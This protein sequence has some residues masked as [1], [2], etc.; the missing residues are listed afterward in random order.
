MSLVMFFLPSLFPSFVL[1]S[2]LPFSMS[3]CLVW[4]L[5]FLEKRKFNLLE[6]K[7]VF[8]SILSVFFVSCLVLSFKSV[9]YLC[10]S[11]LKLCF[12]NNQVFVFRK[13]K[14]VKQ[15]LVNVGVAT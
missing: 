3:S 10:F 4:L 7:A 6:L 1:V 2:L 14:L 13:E 12:I 15:I 11:F 9:S 5:L 8:S